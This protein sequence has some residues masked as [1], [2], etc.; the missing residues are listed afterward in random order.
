MRKHNFLITFIKKFNLQINNLLVKNLNKLNLNNFLH[1]AK[2]NKIFFTFVALIFLCLVYFLIPNTYDRNDVSRELQNQLQ[3]KLNLKF[4]LS[5][6][7]KYN[8]FPRPH[9]T[10]KNSSLLIGQ[11]QISQINDLKIYISL[12]NLFS[13]NNAKIN[14]L[15]LIKSNINLNKNNYD[16]FSQLLN[17]N[18]EDLN[19]AIKDSYIFYRN[20]DDQVLFINKVKNMNYYYNIKESKNVL[21]TENE[22]FNLP[23]SFISS[24]KKNEKKIFSKLNLDFFRLKVENNFDY[25]NDIKKGFLNF[26]FNNIKSNMTYEI[27]KENLLL[28]FFEK[29]KKSNFSYNGNINFSPFHSNFKGSAIEI[30]LVALLNSNNLI[31][32]LLKTEIFNNKNLNLNLNIS[33]DKIKDYHNFVNFI[34]NSKIEE[35]FIDID[36]TKFSW[37]NISDFKIKDSLIYVKNNELVLDGKLN[38][39]IENSDAIFQFLLTPK[40]YRTNLKEIDLDFVYNFDQNILNL[41]NIRIDKRQT[42]NL[43]KILENLIFKRNKLQNKV[44]LKSKLNR[45]LKAYAG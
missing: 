12:N 15:T 24:K 26:I 37:K 32:Q 10:Y 29:S 31:L 21:E 42:K 3:N 39:N 19:L 33:A 41:N 43:D 8:F 20:S 28:N 30:N 5:K 35:G 4:N 40:K 1:L 38:I 44:Y 27:N 17:Q 2:S 18:L 45:A 36:D 14:N 34:L 16:F 9:F 25:N 7:F 13:L 23:Y 11:E 6:S 22:I